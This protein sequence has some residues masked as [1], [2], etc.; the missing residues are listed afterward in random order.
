MITVDM[1]LGKDKLTPL[2]NLFEPLPDV[3][4]QRTT[5]MAWEEP[6]EYNYSK[7]VPLKRRLTNIKN[8]LNSKALQMA[9]NEIESLGPQYNQIQQYIEIL[10]K[11]REAILE[12]RNPDEGDTVD[13]VMQILIKAPDSEP[14]VQ[15]PTN[16]SPDEEAEGDFETNEQPESVPGSPPG[17]KEGEPTPT[18]KIDLPPE[19]HSEECGSCSAWNAQTLTFC[20]QCGA[21]MR[22]QSKG[23]IAILRSKTME[24][25]YFEDIN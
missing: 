23:P 22:N 3:E 7:E 5:P 19:E 1:V 10:Q 21:T 2:D 9:I 24:A 6:F 15:S 14:A 13:A 4:V 17:E 18:I 11:R 25:A 20:K 16:I 8:A 12:D